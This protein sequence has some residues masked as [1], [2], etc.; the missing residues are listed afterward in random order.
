M[1]NP[2]R[3]RDAPDD[4]RNGGLLMASEEVAILDTKKAV[5]ASNCAR[6]THL[7][8]FFFG[9]DVRTFNWRNLPHLPPS[10]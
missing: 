7:M 9:S 3:R 4:V 5:S 8:S 1:P 6:D 10:K 2:A